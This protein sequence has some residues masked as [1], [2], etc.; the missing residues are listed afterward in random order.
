VGGVWVCR[1][2]R[3]NIEPRPGRGWWML[4]MLRNTRK[5]SRRE[6]LDGT[7]VVFH[8]REFIPGCE[9]QNKQTSVPAQAQLD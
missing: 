4:S 6:S 5:A 3:M 7:M 8:P 1:H 2:C 9:A